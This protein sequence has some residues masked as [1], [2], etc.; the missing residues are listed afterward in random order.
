MLIDVTQDNLYI[1]LCSRNLRVD[2]TSYIEVVD[3]AV[4][5]GHN[6][7]S[8]CAPA[9][10]GVSTFADMIGAFYD[11]RTD[12]AV[13]W[14]A[15]IV[16]KQETFKKRG[17]FTVLTYDFTDVNATTSYNTFI[18]DLST[19]TA[20]AIKSMYPDVKKLPRYDWVAL[21]RA[22][23]AESG[24]KLVL[25]FKN[26]DR[27]QRF[28]TRSS[29]FLNAWRRL[30]VSLIEADRREGFIYLSLAGTHIP[31]IADMLVHPE[32]PDAGS[33]FYN[34]SSEKQTGS[35]R[36][37]GW[38]GITYEEMTTILKASFS[39]LD[40]DELY[41]W[42]GHYDGGLV[43]PRTL[44]TSIEAKDLFITSVVSNAVWFIRDSLNSGN[45][46]YL[47]CGDIGIAR[48]LNGEV[49]NTREI[50][51][52]D[53]RN[54]TRYTGE[55]YSY[56]RRFLQILYAE[57]LVSLVT[58]DDS[59][60]D[61]AELVNTEIVMAVS[62]EI[63]AH[64]DYLRELCGLVSRREQIQL[65]L[66]NTDASVLADVL[67]GYLK[68]QKKYLGDSSR[69]TIWQAVYDFISDIENYEVIPFGNVFIIRETAGGESYTV[70]AVAVNADE[71]ELLDV[72]L[73]LRINSA[74]FRNLIQGY[75][76]RINAMI[77]N[78]KLANGSDPVVSVKT[79]LLA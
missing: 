43:K 32:H 23:Y 72:T 22:L 67:C 41:D 45:G 78:F 26:F 28:V 25:I 19:Q 20:Q 37:F 30:W 34:L 38:C 58:R 47:L 39:E 46:A 74:S 16:S 56:T 5:D 73:N 69:V 33:L 11:Q 44:F 57:G 52:F 35:S 10:L 17:G 9:G 55:I 4:A 7:I 77:Y 2:K 13:F 68:L 64:D 24:K 62:D 76:G 49:V 79:T 12:P 59:R 1:S 51:R 66:E 14:G 53:P 75:T 15:D 29:E 8:L 61:V 27:V 48:L 70:I 50:S 65:A 71:N 40:S 6:F 60:L 3:N 18:T 63:N 42:C 31:G 54:N 36:M 21:L